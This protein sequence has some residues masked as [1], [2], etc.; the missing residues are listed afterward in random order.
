MTW[1][2]TPNWQEADQLTGHDNV[3][4]CDYSSINEK[5]KIF[6][7]NISLNILL[8][9]FTLTSDLIVLQSIVLTRTS[10]ETC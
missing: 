9:F 7:K 6:L 1:L 3:N 8:Q 5:I 4:R 10:C 2:K